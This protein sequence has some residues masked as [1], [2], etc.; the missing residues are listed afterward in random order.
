MDALS[1]TASIITILQL[2]SQAVGYINSASGAKEHRKNLREELRSCESILRQLK[3]ESDDSE[4]GKAWSDTIKVLESPDGPL[5]RLSITLDKIVTKLQPKANENKLWQSLKWPFGE[6]EIGEIIA[7]IERE[8]SLL[9]LALANNSRKLIQ[10][11]KKTS[12]ENGKRL[13][14]LTRELEKGSRDTKADI[15]G[16]EDRMQFIQDSHECLHDDLGKLHRHD[17]DHEFHLFLNW[18]A[19]KD[20]SMQQNDF[21]RRRQP[22]T[23]RWLLDSTKFREW[24]DTPTTTLFCPGMPGAG[25]TILTSI[26]VDELSRRFENDNDIGVAYIFCNFRQHDDQ[27]AED[28]LA[29]LLKQLQQFRPLPP[30]MKAFYQRYKNMNRKPCL[31]EISDALRSVMTTYRRVFIIIDALD[32]C[33]SSDRSEEKFLAEVLKLKNNGTANVFVTSR[34]IPKIAAKFEG[35]ISL[36]I[37]ASDDDVGRYIDGQITRLPGF[38]VRHDELRKEIKAGIVESVQ[39]MF[40]LAQLHLDSL[41]GKRSP[42]AVRTALAKLSTG[43]EAYD[44]AYQS[45]MERI[46]GQGPDRRELAKQ[47]LSWIIYAKRPLTTRELRYALAV[48]PWERQMDEENLPQVED[49]VS[50]CAGLVTI[51]KESDIIRL[52]HYTTQEYFERTQERWFANAGSEIT[53]ACITYLSYDVFGSGPC[54]SRDELFERLRINPLYSYAARFWGCHLR[55]APITCNGL[56]GFIQKG[57]YVEAA[58]QVF[59]GFQSHSKEEFPDQNSTGLHLPARF[60]T[61]EATC[62]FAEM[63]K[64]LDLPNYPRQSLLFTPLLE[65]IRKLPSPC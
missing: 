12:E 7:A 49:M 29:N 11:I 26:V 61:L 4:E 38:V 15:S 8:K 23:G 62:A 33:Q 65:N 19:K 27:Q 60:G 56:I 58:A 36:E 2:S 42:K 59:P 9:D 43:S 10:G 22:G 57:P 55:S 21:I 25:K 24:V 37:R 3:D 13:L 32:E 41:T 6:K 51:D 53:T 31:N 46:E 34:L 16:L 52:V 30:S 44:Y 17:D 39:G 47:V 5:G 48:E 1:I 28:L 20:Y 40:L 63:M 54:V 50:A 14:E 35:A 45:A 18:L 64:I